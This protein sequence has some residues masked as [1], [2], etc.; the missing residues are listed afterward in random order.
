MHS[1]SQPGTTNEF[2]LH[3]Q[4][5]S[6]LL[7]D[8][9]KQSNFFIATCDQQLRYRW[10][11][12]PPANIAADHFIDHT[13]DELFGPGGLQI[14]ALKQ[15]ALSSNT[16]IEAQIALSLAGQTVRLAL[17][18]IPQG[19][20]ADHLLCIGR[21]LSDQPIALKPA[22]APLW[23]YLGD[24]PTQYALLDLIDQVVLVTI[25]DGRL[26]YANQAARQL[27]GI[28]IAT[29]RG[30]ILDGATWGIDRA[31]LQRVSEHIYRGKIWQGEATGRTNDGR[32][33]DVLLTCRPI[34]NSDGVLQATITTAVDIGRLKEA[35]AELR[36]VNHL[37]VELNRD[38]RHSRNLL[39][40]LFNGIEDALCLFDREG[41]LLALNQ[42]AAEILEIAD[43]QHEEYQIPAFVTDSPFSLTAFIRQSLREQLPQR[44]R[45]QRTNAERRQI[46]DVQTLPQFDDNGNL[47]RLVIH[48][49]DVTEQVLIEAQMIEQERLAANGRLAAT[50]AHEINTPLQAIESCLHLIGRVTE[51]RRE[52]YLNLARDE[53]RRI[54]EIVQRLLNHYQPSN[55]N[56]M[57]VMLNHLVER[58]LM[59]T[60]ASLSRQHIRVEQTLCDDLPP[61]L[62]RADELTQVLLNLVIN[63][64]HAMPRGGIL[65]LETSK[66]AAEPLRVLLAVIDNG[67]GIPQE[68]QSRIFEPY[69]TTRNTGSGLG[70]A[71]CQRI[72]NAHG[73]ELS[74][75]SSLGHGSRFTVALP[76]IAS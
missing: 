65:R 62:G 26:F 11:F 5:G 19:H 42:R 43:H 7:R 48:A 21:P 31:L 53:I 6:D 28:D 52:R 56:P 4:P 47:M 73:G 46:L 54:G 58:V 29:M 35:E 40:M 33:Y 63:A 61:V 34:L 24:D 12:N 74:V 39:H 22:D 57:P 66:E 67:V 3:P 10:V 50:L 14:K 59:L 1:I 72:I 75:Q 9:L 20:P 41:K 45:I 32:R 55:P 71:V 68:D 70:L 37:L 13:D 2:P 16:P 51:D 15:Q 30:R 17:Q 49:N 27:Y 38:Y 25:E 76:I 64:A 18:I 36:Q 60:G 8:A 23:P 69:F 44:R